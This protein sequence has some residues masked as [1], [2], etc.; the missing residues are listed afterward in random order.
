MALDGLFG[1]ADTIVT[2]VGRTLLETRAVPT[3]IEL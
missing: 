2:D 3:L 1:T